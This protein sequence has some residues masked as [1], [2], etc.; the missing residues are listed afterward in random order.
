MFKCVCSSQLLSLCFCLEWSIGLSPND[1]FLMRPV[2]V[3]RH[4]ASHMEIKDGLFW[5]NGQVTE[6]SLREAGVRYAL[7]T[8]FPFLHLGMSLP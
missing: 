5:Y 2:T 1:S 4:D 6:Y 8:L 7:W 3:A